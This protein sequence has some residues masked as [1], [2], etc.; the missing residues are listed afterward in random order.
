MRAEW[1]S[2]PRTAFLCV[3]LGCM[4]QLP[5]WIMALTARPQ[6][7]RRSLASVSFMGSV[8]AVASVIH[9]S[10]LHAPHNQCFAF[11]PP[12]SLLSRSFSPSFCSSS[13]WFCSLHSLTPLCLSWFF[14]PCF[15][16]SGSVLSCLPYPFLFSLSPFPTPPSPSCPLFFI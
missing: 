9:A 12:L 10:P 4:T 8:L 5:P 7:G 6:R 16:S 15:S 11:F 3:A 2:R 13:F 14:C 1:S